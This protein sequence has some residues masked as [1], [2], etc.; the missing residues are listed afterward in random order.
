MEKGV[1]VNFLCIGICWLIL[2]GWV[3]VQPANAQSNRKVKL[4]GTVYEF[5]QQ[6]ER[7]PLS[8]ATVSIPDMALGTTTN[9]QGR[10]ILGE[11]PHG[12]VRMQIQ[13]LGKLTVDTLLHVNRDLVLNFTMKNE[14]FTLKEVTVTATNNRSGKSTSSHISRAAMD[15][16]QANSLYDLM[17]LM[18]GGIS[19]NQNMNSAQQITIRQIASDKGPEAMN[20]LGTAIIRDGAPISNNANLSAMNPTVLNG[21]DTPS[22]LAGGASPAGGTDV[23]SISTENIE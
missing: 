15:H 10:Y 18:P 20:A 4:S 19:E 1:R 17:A 11:V 16:M 22:A 8:F 5:N 21:T 3:L 23:R 12:Q 13:F 6:N 7:V 14:D 2:A 9:E